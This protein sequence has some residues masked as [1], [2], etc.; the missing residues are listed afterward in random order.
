MADGAM[1][2]CRD[3]GGG[4]VN[5]LNLKIW[6]GVAAEPSYMAQ[7]RSRYTQA[8]RN[9]TAAAAAEGVQP[10]QSLMSVFEMTLRVLASRLDSDLEIVPS[11]LNSEAMVL[12]ACDSE[13]EIPSHLQS[14]G[15]PRRDS[16]RCQIRHSG[17]G[18]HLCC[19][20]RAWAD[21]DGASTCIHCRRR[22]AIGAKN[23]R[24]V[25]TICACNNVY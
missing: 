22:A 17:L 3:Q 14:S 23:F 18:C 20:I 10:S 21:E 25:F 6:I 5:T 1:F 2:V 19:S 12:E 4:Q 11:Q 15:T 16:T 24:F 7:A 13:P 8:D 9:R